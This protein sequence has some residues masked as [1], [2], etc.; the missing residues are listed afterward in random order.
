MQLM[1]PFDGTVTAY[2]IR[3]LGI[4]MDSKHQQTQDLSLAP[5]LMSK[6]PLPAWNT[7][8]VDWTAH[9]IYHLTEEAL[10]EPVYPSPEDQALLSP[11]SALHYRTSLADHGNSIYKDFSFSQPYPGMQVG[12]AI[13]SYDP[14]IQQHQQQSKQARREQGM[15]S[16]PAYM[17]PN[18]FSVDCTQSPSQYSLTVPVA[19]PMHQRE[20]SPNSPPPLSQPGCSPSTSGPLTPTCPP[21]RRLSTPSELQAFTDAEPLHAEHLPAEPL[22]IAHT[23]TKNTAR[24]SCPKIPC[25]T[26]KRDLKSL[27]RHVMEK[28]GKPAPGEIKAGWFRCACGSTACH[29]RKANHTRHLN[30]CKPHKWSFKEFVCQ[31]GRKH[32]NKADHTAHYMK[33]NVGKNPVGRPRGAGPNEFPASDA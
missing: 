8:F 14:G 11:Y 4:D 10:I 13:V 12:Q 3:D 32:S 33:C 7:E 18:P 31:C 21:S 30:N 16:N 24:F 26:I 27:Q 17:S 19:G 1:R 23:P 29:Y 6:Q 28:H 20:A 25:P 5:S 2:G 15:V 22:P 9:S